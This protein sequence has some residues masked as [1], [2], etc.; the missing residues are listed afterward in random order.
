MIL[1]SMNMRALVQVL[2][3]LSSVRKGGVGGKK[4]EGRRQIV[5][6]GEIQWIRLM[7]DPD[8][9]SGGGYSWF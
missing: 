2:Y 3:R 1:E 9:F 7:D 5:L 4:R 6:C 8:G